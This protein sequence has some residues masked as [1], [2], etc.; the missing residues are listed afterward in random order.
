MS[1]LHTAHC[2]LPQGSPLA[3]LNTIPPINPLPLSPI[4]HHYQLLP[5]FSCS[6]LTSPVSPNLMSFACPMLRMHTTSHLL[7]CSMAHHLCSTCAHCPSAPPMLCMQTTPHM[8]PRR[9]DRAE[10]S[11]IKQHGHHV[12][13]LDEITPQ[14]PFCYP[15]LVTSLVFF[16]IYRSISSS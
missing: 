12:V 5:S 13:S 10:A 15:D 14:Q 1:T 16:T 3:H 8:N 2:P 4:H 7:P 11:K 6:C 9:E